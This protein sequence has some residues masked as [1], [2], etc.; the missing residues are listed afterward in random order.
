LSAA[1]S[2][3][4]AGIDSALSVSEVS[5]EGEDPRLHPHLVTARLLSTKLIRLDMSCA[6]KCAVR[7]LEQLRR[8]Y[9][10]TEP[11]APEVPVG[12]VLAYFFGPP[13]DVE[14]PKRLLTSASP[15]ATKQLMAPN[16][17]CMTRRCGPQPARCD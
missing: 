16:P 15:D 5:R 8:Y 9:P 7:T 2:K 14:G 3:T 13:L 11:M 17:G 1:S 12:T 4:G 10:G 6:V